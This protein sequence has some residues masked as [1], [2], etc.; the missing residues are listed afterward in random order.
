MQ[1]GIMFFFPSIS[2]VPTTGKQINPIYLKLL[3]LKPCLLPFV[4]GDKSLIIL[5]SLSCTFVLDLHLFIFMALFIDSQNK[6]NC[7]SQNSNFS[8]TWKLSCLGI[9]LERSCHSNSFFYCSSCNIIP[10]NSAF[11]W[12]W[13][14]K[15]YDLR[16]AL[17]YSSLKQ[18]LIVFITAE[19]EWGV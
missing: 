8:Q 11:S 18:V 4:C 5:I 3:Q 2:G 14:R 6:K 13:L 19:G 10:F 16:R 1:G 15:L 17:Y 12:P 9:F 7:P